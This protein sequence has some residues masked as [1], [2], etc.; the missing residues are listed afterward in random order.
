[1]V[2]VSLPIQSPEEVPLPHSCGREHPG[3]LFEPLAP[4]VFDRGPRPMPRYLINI[5]QLGI[6]LKW[7]LSKSYVRLKVIRLILSESDGLGLILLLVKLL[8]VILIEG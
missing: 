3:G 1:M 7:R 4:E 2:Y 5:L 8:L 6:T